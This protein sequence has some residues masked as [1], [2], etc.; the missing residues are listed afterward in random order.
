MTGSEV[1]V[2]IDDVELAVFKSQFEVNGRGGIM[3][4]SGFKRKISFKDYR[5]LIK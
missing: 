4:S 5:I 1:K 2:L 3:L